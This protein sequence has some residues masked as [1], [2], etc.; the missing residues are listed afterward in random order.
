[1]KECFLS[2]HLNHGLV[3]GTTISLES[4]LHLVVMYQ[5]ICQILPPPHTPLLPTSARGDDV[6]NY[7]ADSNSFQITMVW[8]RQLLFCKYQ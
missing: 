2:G 4:Q 5:W 1:M 3:F 6:I 7:C 8:L